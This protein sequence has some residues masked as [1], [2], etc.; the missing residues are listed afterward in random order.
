MCSVTDANAVHVVKWKIQSFIVIVC[1]GTIYVKNKHLV[2][3]I[4]LL[5]CSPTHKLDVYL[6][7]L[8]LL[9][10]QDFLI[11]TF[12]F[13]RLS[14]D[15]VGTKHVFRQERIFVENIFSLVPSFQT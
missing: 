4:V 7:F 2:K 11:L 5:K 14:F 8:T 3:S 15:F 1:D 9:D 12:L 10:V 6:H 13:K